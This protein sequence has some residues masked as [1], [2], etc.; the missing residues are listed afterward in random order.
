MGRKA[1]PGISYYRLNCSHIRNKKVRLLFNEFDADGYW[2]WQCLL[3]TAYEGQGYYFDFNDKET[4]ELFATDVCKK[5]VSVVEEVIRGC[6]RRDLFSKDVFDVFGILTSEM[7]QEVYLDATAERRRKGTAIEIFKELLLVKIQD[8]TRNILIVPW[9][10]E[11]VPRKNGIDPGNNPQSREDK[12]R[13]EESK[14]DNRPVGLVATDVASRDQRRELKKKYENL[15]T[16]LT[17][18]KSKAEIW[19]ELRDFISADH[20]EFIEPYVEAWNLFAGSYKLS[21]V[22]D[23]TKSR[24]K[25]FDTRIQE[26]SFDFLKVLERIKM[27]THLRGDNSGSW[28]V[29]FDWILENDK[30]YLKILEENYN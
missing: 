1:E 16:N 5:P 4:L 10:K 29:T 8:D 25:K 27:S 24:R 14:V 26:K 18:G 9:K 2:I 13:G 19:Q 23:I 28:K 17:E 15:V 6:I 7:M 30:N 21:Q 11:I 3:A 20:P 22:K 12:R